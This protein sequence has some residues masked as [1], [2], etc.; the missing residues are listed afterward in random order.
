MTIACRL[1]LL[2]LTDSK[3]IC[4]A[5]EF[6]PIQK[7]EGNSIAPG[8]KVLIAGATVKAG[9]I[10]VDTRSL[11]VCEAA[12]YCSQGACC[13]PHCAMSAGIAPMDE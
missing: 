3:T 8:A 4:K 6:R 1:L 2:K 12:L 10:L 5:L 9:I 11:K 13:R 7:A